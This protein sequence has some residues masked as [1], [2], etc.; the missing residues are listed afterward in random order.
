MPEPRIGSLCTGYG[1]LDAAVQAVFGGTTTWVSD[2]EPGAARILTHRMPGVPNLG[3][4]TTT[5]WQAVLDEHGPVD[6]VTG[7]YPCQPFS[8]AGRRKGTSDARHIW[9][10]IAD[11]LRVLRPRY[12]IFENVAGHL[13][14]GFDTV[15]RDLAAIGFDAEWCLVRAS[16]IGAPHQRNRLFVLSVNSDTKGAGRQGEGLRGRAAERDGAAADAADLGHERGRD[17]RRRGHGPADHGQP[18]SDA[19]GRGQQ[20]HPER[21]GRPD[22]GQPE[23]EPRLDTDGRRVQREA[24]AHPASLGRGE[25]RPEPARLERRPGLVSGSTPDW[26]PYA[27]AIARWEAVTGRRAP[28]ATDDRRRLNPAFVEWLMGLPAGW[29]THVPELTRTQQLKALGNGVVPQQAEA[30]IRLLHTRA[31]T[32]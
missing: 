6:I 25:G 4:L 27:P 3:D 28:W 31:G 32:A 8:V 14:L 26:G 16:E 15:L 9:P 21:H 18:A 10:H 24:P 30:A 29:V 23:R 22:D 12:A 1:G 13:R 17:T 19:D 7:G 2:I 20:G 11:A 5:N